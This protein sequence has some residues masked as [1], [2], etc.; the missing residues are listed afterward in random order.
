MYDIEIIQIITQG[1]FAEVNQAIHD[2]ET[3]N[4]QGYTGET[5]LMKACR[6]V[7]NEPELKKDWLVEMLLEKKEKF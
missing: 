2:R 6:T 7:M 5:L 3:A 4:A 1:T